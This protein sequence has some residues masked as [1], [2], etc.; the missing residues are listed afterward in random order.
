M[1]HMWLMDLV[2]LAFLFASMHFWWPIVGV[3]HDPAL[4]DEPRH[5]DGAPS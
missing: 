1:T 4:A 5:E 3:D 2:N